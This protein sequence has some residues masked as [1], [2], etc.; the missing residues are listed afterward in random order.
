MIQKE[1]I[2]SRNSKSI[3]DRRFILYWMQASQRAEWNHALEYAI[4]Q[5][6]EREKP[7]LTVFVLTDAFPEANRRHYAFM[8]QGLQEVQAAL[9]Q[10]NI[11]LVILRGN[12]VKTIPA[13]AKQADML[14]MDD[15]Y[16]PI[17]RQWR[18][19]IAKSVDCLA[20]EV[21]ANLIVPVEEASD[22]ANFSAG[23]FR[24]RIHK[25]L[26][27]YLVPL[28]HTRPRCSSLDLKF[29][30]IDISDVEK[31]LKQLNVDHTI[32]PSLFFTAA[33]R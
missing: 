13:L 24:P 15:G 23:T 9:A 32:I 16:L 2:H 25:Q 27:K 3:Q 14:V 17:Q 5:A 19:S 26:H 28:K 12:P 29:E 20:C 10:R 31:T 11:H 22:K 8:L 33:I 4:L 6:N 30:S 18:D 7:I 21:A 1:R